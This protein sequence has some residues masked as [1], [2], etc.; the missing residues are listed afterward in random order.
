MN[1]CLQKAAPGEAWSGA[2]EGHALNAHVLEEDKKR[3]LLERFQTEVVRCISSS[4]MKT[5]GCYGEQH[6]GFDFSGA[7]VTGDAPNPRTFLKDIND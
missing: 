5:D 1:I 4:V 7:E 2:F 3:L 6:A